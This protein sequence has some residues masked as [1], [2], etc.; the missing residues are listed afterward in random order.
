MPEGTRG[1]LSSVLP[2]SPGLQS[3]YLDSCSPAV[4]AL[5]TC[6]GTLKRGEGGS[7]LPEKC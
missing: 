7:K 6:L 3:S 2:L 1:P 5:G 4:K